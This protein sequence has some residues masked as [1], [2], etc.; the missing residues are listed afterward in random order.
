M[1]N[2]DLVNHDEPACLSNFT[3]CKAVLFHGWFVLCVIKCVV[4]LFASS[5]A[6]Q[7]MPGCVGV[8]WGMLGYSARRWDML[9]NASDWCMPGYARVCGSMLGAGTCW[10]ML[11]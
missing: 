10:G 4:G 5:F 6:W 2:N 9:G 3:A 8:R 11:C 1:I 7:G